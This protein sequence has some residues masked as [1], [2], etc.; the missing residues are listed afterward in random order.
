[1]EPTPAASVAR[2]AVHEDAQSTGVCER[3]GNFVCPL[4]LDPFSA[5][6]DHCE[7][8]RERE[9]ADVIAWE[10]PE[11]TMP[12][13]FWQTTKDLLA[14]PSDTFDRVQPGS[15]QAAIAY[16]AILGL[17]G[18]LFQGLLIGCLFAVGLAG[19]LGDAPTDQEPAMI[20]LTSILI[21]G[22]MPFAGVLQTLF[23]SCAGGLLYH[24]GAWIVGGRGGIGTS[25]W[26][27]QYLQAIMMI[28][29]P[30]SLLQAVPILGSIVMLFAGLAV[31]VW[32]TIRLTHVGQRFHGLTQGR[33]VF[34][35]LFPMLGVVALMVLVF[36]MA[37]FVGFASA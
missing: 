20:A 29:W 3:C 1:M 28:W 13:R 23:N 15:V 4:C 21:V 11:G 7:A 34:A 33:A 8:C 26:A 22:C 5:F 18:G 37:L 16:A 12:A 36:A 35:A 9:G 25:L 10:R 31:F 19:T 27:N 32:Y 6:P 30:L 14:R 2:C 24:L 17:I